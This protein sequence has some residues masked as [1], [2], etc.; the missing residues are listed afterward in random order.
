MTGSPFE[1]V[2]REAQ[3]IGLALDRLLQERLSG[4][5]GFVLVLTTMGSE[6]CATYVT[7]FDSGDALRVIE[8]LVENRRGGRAFDD[9]D[10]SIR[11]W[12]CD[13]PETSIVVR[14]PNRVVHLCA[15]CWATAS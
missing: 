3:A 15:S 2:E 1:M 11:C 9:A 6:G 7:N 14:G 13:A 10:L 8:E 4:K 5:T 12:C